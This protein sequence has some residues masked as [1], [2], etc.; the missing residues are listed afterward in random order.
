MQVLV[1][2]AFVATI[3]ETS[4]LIFLAVGKPKV[5]TALQLYAS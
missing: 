3:S 4:G 1:V 5:D 2:A